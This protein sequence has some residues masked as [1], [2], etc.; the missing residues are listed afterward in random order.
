MRAIPEL[1]RRIPLHCGLL[2]NHLT[3]SA[4]AALGQDELTKVPVESHELVGSDLTRWSTGRNQ[5]IAFRSNH[6]LVSGQSIVEEVM[7]HGRPYIEVCLK[8]QAGPEFR[9]IVT[10][11][12]SASGLWILK[13]TFKDDEVSSRSHSRVL[14]ID[15][16]V[17]T[18]MLT[19]GWR[20]VES[21]HNRDRAV[22]RSIEVLQLGLISWTLNREAI[23]GSTIV[24][25]GQTT[26][27]AARCAAPAR[28]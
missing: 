2:N 18:A 19:V 10:S 11:H 7:N 17:L 5:T 25:T 14:R 21:I 27:G 23:D 3:V 6:W 13:N 24:I 4:R 8:R 1:W 28:S 22:A 15:Q 26:H 12:Q 16:S 9:H 20:Q